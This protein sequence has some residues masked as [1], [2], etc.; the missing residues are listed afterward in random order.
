MDCVK[1]LVEYLLKMLTFARNMLTLKTKKERE[2]D[3]EREKRKRK[4][5]FRN[6]KVL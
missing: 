2:R 6:K 1:I 3:R 5:K 4:I